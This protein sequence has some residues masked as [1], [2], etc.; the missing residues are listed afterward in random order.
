MK[1]IDACSSD[2]TR[3]EPRK[4][5]GGAHAMGGRGFGRVPQ[6]QPPSKLSKIAAL[7]DLRK[8]FR[9]EIQHAHLSYE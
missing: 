5:T 3:G 7:E 2:I 6:L 9:P 8:H 4:N 1:S